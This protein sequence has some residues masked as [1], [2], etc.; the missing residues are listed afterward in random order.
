MTCCSCYRL[1]PKCIFSTNAR[2]S[3]Q[4]KNNAKTLFFHPPFPFPSNFCNCNIGGIC[5]ALQFYTQCKLTPTQKSA[6]KWRCDLSRLLAQK[7]T[8]GIHSCKPASLNRPIHARD[9]QND[10]L[11]ETCLK[12]TNIHM[13][14]NT[15]WPFAFT[16]FP[17]PNTPPP[18]APKLLLSL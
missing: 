17:P 12:R 15:F 10:F 18:P 7:I 16:R 1:P 14:L 8:K 6:R 5:T 4:P 11:P 2:S 3:G 9:H 13:L